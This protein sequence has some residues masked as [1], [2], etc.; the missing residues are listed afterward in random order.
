ML[1]VGI[2]A[3]CQ[4][5]ALMVSEDGLSLARVRMTALKLKVFYFL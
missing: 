5:M 1:L 3:S 4:V 2:G